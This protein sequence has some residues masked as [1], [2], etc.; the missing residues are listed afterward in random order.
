M[1]GKL[2]LYR[3][4]RYTGFDRV[5]YFDN[6]DDKMTWLSSAKVA[7]FDDIKIKDVFNIKIKGDLKKDFECNYYRLQFTTHDMSDYV[8]HY[9]F[10]DEVTY[11]NDDCVSLELSLDVL[12]TYI[13]KISFQ[14]SL[15]ERMSPVND[16]AKKR[17]GFFMLGGTGDKL[18]YKNIYPFN[19]EITAI[20]V[21]NE[22]L[23]T[24]TD[25][26][27]VT[28]DNN[29]TNSSS[30]QYYYYSAFYYYA[31][32]TSGLRDIMLDINSQGKSEGVVSCYFI[33]SQIVPKPTSTMAKKLNGYYSYTFNVSISDINTYFNEFTYKEH[34]KKSFEF[35]SFT[36]CDNVGHE[37]PLHYG[38]LYKNGTN[39]PMIAYFV[40]NADGE[41]VIGPE[42]FNG[43]N[44]NRDAFLTIKCP[45]GS[46]ICDNYK[47]WK[48]T[49]SELINL[50]QQNAIE[51]MQLEAFYN[52]IDYNIADKIGDRRTR[53]NIANAGISGVT[54]LLK[55][56]LAGSAITANNAINSYFDNEVNKNSHKLAMSRMDSSIAKTKE[57]FQQI[58][59]L[60]NK[61][62]QKMPNSV[63]L[64]SYGES[65]CLFPKI[66]GSSVNYSNICSIKFKAPPKSDID[67]ADEQIKQTGYV[68]GDNY[69]LDLSLLPTGNTFVKFSIVQLTC[70]A[71][72]TI[73]NKIKDCFKNG[74]MIIKS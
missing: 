50:N 7:E 60:T 65:E 23:S 29:N 64:R 32:S 10:V 34:F 46:V 61:I 53:A 1:N 26:S 20:L 55:G 13:D 40:P 4:V 54:G 33:P 72:N 48:A 21:T 47:L 6:D 3:N 70:P 12:F 66:G 37:L 41:F 49:N 63:V 36:I 59:S 69:N 19:A 35:N 56:D 39:V 30:N 57:D 58:N 71:D 8:I 17:E 51:D 52:S 28:I 38:L 42:E 62:K 67:V 18:T 43:I 15:I 22:D 5:K 14:N 27:N 16:F 9:G 2:T 74:V 31:C 25:N 68:V 24:M 44:Y 45:Q 11:L 73:V